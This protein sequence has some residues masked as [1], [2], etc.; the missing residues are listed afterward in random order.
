[1]TGQSRFYEEVTVAPAEGGF[2]VALDRKP[3][4]TPMGAHLVLPAE[5]LANAIADEW[6]AQSADLKPDTMPLTR[7]ANTAIDKIR[8]DPDATAALILAFGKTDVLCYRAEEP[9]ALVERQKASWDRL[10]DWAH[11]RY[12]A[13][14]KVTF[15]IGFVEQPPE[16]LAAL[17]RALT[18]YDAFDLAGLHAAAAILGSQVLALALA[19]RMLD[20]VEAFDHGHLDETYQSNLWGEDSE[21]QRKRQLLR[22]ELVNIERFFRLVRP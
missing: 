22:T 8:S 2:S 13:R 12:G 6:R 19:E 7:L 14:L 15:G 11:K 10:L 1:M 9:A 5:A 4:R 20:A 17:E 16:A 18:G 21:A 3:I